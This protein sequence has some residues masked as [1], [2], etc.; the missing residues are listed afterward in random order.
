MVGAHQL[1][2]VWTEQVAEV[3]PVRGCAGR[4]SGQHPAAWLAASR[5]TSGERRHVWLI[6][7]VVPGRPARMGPDTGAAWTGSAC[8]DAGVGAWSGRR[9]GLCS[10]TLLQG[11]CP[12]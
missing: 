7:G 9:G 5:V 1:T 3:P 12:G 8:Q 4:V 6:C 11:V 2:E 10:K